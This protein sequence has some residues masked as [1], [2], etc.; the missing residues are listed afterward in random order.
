MA[1]IRLIYRHTHI[2]CFTGEREKQKTDLA[3]PIMS[4][5]SSNSMYLGHYLNMHYNYDE[6]IEEQPTSWSVMSRKAQT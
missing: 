3:Y 1:T 5:Q 4:Q 2:Y 6:A